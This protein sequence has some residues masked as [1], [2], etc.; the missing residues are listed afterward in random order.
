MKLKHTRKSACDVCIRTSLLPAGPRGG[1]VVFFTR[2]PSFGVVVVSRSLKGERVRVIKSSAFAQLSP[3]TQRVSNNVMC[4]EKRE[5]LLHR[6]LFVCCVCAPL[7]SY[8]SKRSQKSLSSAE[9]RPLGLLLC[10]WQ[11]KKS[12]KNF[13]TSSNQTPR[14][15]S[16]HRSCY[17]RPLEHQQT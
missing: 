11:N 5:S 3:Q 4:G 17:Q 15:K 2:P 6:S 16:A 9:L 10:L 7:S 8:Y 12:K 13:K 14:Q 1:G